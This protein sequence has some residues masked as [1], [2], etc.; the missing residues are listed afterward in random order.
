[1]VIPMSPVFAHHVS[2]NCPVVSS[3]NS[4][5]QRASAFYVEDHTISIKS[6]A[7]ISPMLFSSHKDEAGVL[8]LA[9]GFSND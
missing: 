1:M 2:V 9:R 8:S 3:I 6:S 4:V 5:S 7:E